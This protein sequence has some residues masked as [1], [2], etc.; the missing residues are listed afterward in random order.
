MAQIIRT[1][2]Y[3]KLGIL[4]VRELHTDFP[5]LSS[6][7][8]DLERDVLGCYLPRSLVF[9]DFIFGSRCSLHVFFLFF[10]PLLFCQGGLKKIEIRLILFVFCF[11]CVS[12]FFVI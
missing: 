11:C 10:P 3:V 1:Y 4:A 5:F 2:P 8:Q 7:M 12:I 6:E 9:C